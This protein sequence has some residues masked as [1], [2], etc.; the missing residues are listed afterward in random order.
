MGFITLGEVTVET[1][2]VCSVCRPRKLE[3]FFRDVD[4]MSYD[5][6]VDPHELQQRRRELNV[7]Q[8]EWDLYQEKV[9]D[10]WGVRH[11]RHPF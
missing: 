1:E 3:E 10:S 5:D 11:A 8:Y 7:T 6:S 4:R 9:D 2:H